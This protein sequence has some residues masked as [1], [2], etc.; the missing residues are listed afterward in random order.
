M[1]SDSQIK[2][3]QLELRDFIHTNE[4]KAIVVLR[5]V[6]FDSTEIEHLFGLTIDAQEFLLYHVEELSELFTTYD[7]I[8]NQTESELLAQQA[9]LA[10]RFKARLLNDPNTPMATKNSIA[11]EFIER[12]HGKARQQIEQINFNL[13]PTKSIENIDKLIAQELERIK[14]L[15]SNTYDIEGETVSIAA[16]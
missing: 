5:A 7:I 2:E 12:V 9:K 14:R 3:F 1:L 6:G 15:E 11:T 8:T 13:D 16:G 4:A 10:L